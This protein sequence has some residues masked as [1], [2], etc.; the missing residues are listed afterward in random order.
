MYTR[1]IG[2]I[3][4]KYFYLF[5]YSGYLYCASSSSLLLRGALLIRDKAAFYGVCVLQC[6]CKVPFLTWPVLRCPTPS[7]DLCYKVS[8]RPPQAC[9]L[10]DRKGHCLSVR[11]GHWV[12]YQRIINC[13]SC[14]SGKSYHWPMTALG[15]GMLHAWLIWHGSHVRWHEPHDSCHMDVYVRK[16]YWNI[17]VHVYASTNRSLTMLSS[18][19]SSLQS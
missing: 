15:Y 17:I 10:S 12:L 4:I 13:S 11:K 18:N 5:I 2:K 8:K 1:S 9:C 14:E 3:I 6:L 7:N 19:R 16:Y